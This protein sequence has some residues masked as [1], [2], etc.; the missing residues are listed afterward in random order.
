[1]R[2][3]ISPSS[4]EPIIDDTT[5]AKYPEGC[6]RYLGVKHLIKASDWPRQEIHP[7][8]SAIG[9]VAEEF[10]N[11]EF[12]SSTYVD[13]EVPLTFDLGDDVWINGRADYIL[14]DRVIEVKATI[15]QSKRAQWRKGNMLPGHL[16]QTK[17]YML[18]AD[19]DHGTIRAFY[20]HFTREGLTLSLE[21]FIHVI[22]GL[23]NNDE[24]E[25]SKFYLTVKEA[26]IGNDLA[27]RPVS[28]EPCMR[29]PFRAVCETGLKLKE[30]FVEEIG[31]ILAGDPPSHTMMVPK[32]KV[33]NRR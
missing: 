10:I 20:M 23:S 28:L 21:P 18:L 30:D 12:D 8:Y 29:C 33:H 2:Y 11:S 15:S 16:G 1:M 19:K 24:K 5:N 3:T 6:L 31:T 13:R 4:Y 9:T 25:L 32:I 26:I 7:I 27:P 17:T 22:S 14:E